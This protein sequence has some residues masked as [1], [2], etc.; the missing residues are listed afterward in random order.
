MEKTK[1]SPEMMATIRKTVDE[2][3]AKIEKEEKIAIQLFHGLNRQSPPQSAELALFYKSLGN[4]IPKLPNRE[5]QMIEHPTVEQLEQYCKNHNILFND[6]E[7]KPCE[8][9]LY[10]LRNRA[11]EKPANQRMPITWKRPNEFFKNDK[12]Q[13]EVVLFN[14]IEPN[15]IKQGMLGDCW[16]MCR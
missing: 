9:S 16:L 14:T 15:D 6:W 5:G 13:T 2:F 1:M 8:D 4:S 7:F 3:N 11:D 10:R 12:D